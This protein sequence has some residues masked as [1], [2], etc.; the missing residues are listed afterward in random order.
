MGRYVP[1][2]KV[3]EFLI[4]VDSGDRK[5]VDRVLAETSRRADGKDTLDLLFGVAAMSVAVL[6]DAHGDEWKAG[7]IA[8]ARKI[9]GSGRG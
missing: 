1:T 5:A 7:M 9:R 4:A 6:R 2:S 3:M 8:A